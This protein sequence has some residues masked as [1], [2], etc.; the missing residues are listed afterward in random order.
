[1]LGILIFWIVLAT[2][3]PVFAAVAAALIAPIGAYLVAA[4]QMSGKIGSSQATD[5]WKESSA[6]RD[7]AT[8]RIDKCDEEILRLNV[9]L[10]TARGR[11]DEL[12]RDNRK[13]TRQLA[14]QGGYFDH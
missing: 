9:E 1:M 3:D 11:I 6:I 10:A 7:W 13:L 2:V 12:E 8:A 14:E 4:R 5:L